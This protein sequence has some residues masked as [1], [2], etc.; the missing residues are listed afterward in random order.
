MGAKTAITVTLRLLACG[1]YLV[2]FQNQAEQLS[3]SLDADLATYY[4]YQWERPSLRGKEVDGNAAGAI[5]EALAQLEPLGEEQRAALANQLFYGQRIGEAEQPLVEAHA[6]LID[7]LRTATQ[8][9]R[10]KTQL[11]LHQGQEL[12]VPP[13]PRAL[14]AALL[15]FAHALLAGPDLCLEVAADTI[16]MGQDLVPGGPLE[17]ASVSAR[18]TSLSRPVVT[19]CAKQASDDAVKRAAHEFHNLA[20]HAPPT[21][22]GIEVEDLLIGIELRRRTALEVTDPQAPMWA[23]VKNRP[24]L[25][26]AWAYYG[27]P[28]RWRKLAPDSYPDLLNEW[29]REHEWR[30]RPGLGLMPE[31]TD[32][33]LG[34]IYDDM[35]GQATLRALAVGLGT[36]AER[37]RRGKMPPEPV[38]IGDRA[39]AD[40]FNRQPLKWRLA[41]GGAEL[42]LWSVG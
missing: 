13:Y 9:G 10:S 42:S 38:S 18:I 23:K 19:S 22:M 41:Q 5:F 25:V 14:D 34:W 15:L 32:G 26:K 37:I 8:R 35:R 16:R 4:R 27:D 24:E 40:P 17:A 28:T 29:R 7:K 21:G 12:K 11:A 6:E 3:E 39:L 30:Q 2:H 31:L 1:G 20:T 36:L 33:V